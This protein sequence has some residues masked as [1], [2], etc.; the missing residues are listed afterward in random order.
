MIFISNKDNKLISG[1][2]VIRG[3]IYLKLSILVN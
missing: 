3:Y 1:L 2:Q